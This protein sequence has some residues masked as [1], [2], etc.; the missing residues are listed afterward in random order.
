MHTTHFHI[1][2]SYSKCSL[3]KNL[4]KGYK[5]AQYAQYAHYWLNFHF[6]SIIIVDQ[7]VYQYDND[8]RC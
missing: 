3:F 7:L 6:G 8:L 2:Y 5:H 4:L 1:V